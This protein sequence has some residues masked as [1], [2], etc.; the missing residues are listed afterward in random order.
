MRPLLVDSHAHLN[1]AAYLED[2]PEVVER[3][4][5]AGVGAILVVGYD[6]KSSQRAKELAYE[7][8]GV[9][10][11]VGIHPHDAPECTESAL[12]TLTSMLKDPRVKALGEIGLDYYWNTWP[13]EVQQR[14][15]RLQLNLAKRLSVPFIVHDRDAHGDVLAL[16]K[17]QAPYKDGFVMHCFSGSPEFARECLRLGGH[18]SL[19]GPVTFRNAFKLVEVAL[20]VPLDRLLLE[21]D[22]PYLSPDPFRGKRNEPARVTR[23]AEAIALIKGVEYEQVAL[24]TTGNAT[25][26]FGMEVRS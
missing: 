17:E 19:A 24:A 12:E 20:E 8:P 11:A 25:R 14:A 6:L 5:G 4:F 26:L 21:T 16:L 7:Y 18:I 3:A 9:H 10:A 15:F 2:L 1:D 13:K 22:C 23:V